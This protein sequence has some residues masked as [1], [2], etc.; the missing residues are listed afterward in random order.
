MQDAGQSNSNP[1]IIIRRHQELAVS[2]A[3]GI[4]NPVMTLRLTLLQSIAAQFYDNCT[5]VITQTIVQLI[6]T[7]QGSLINIQIMCTLKIERTV[8]IY[9][10]YTYKHCIYDIFLLLLLSK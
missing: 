3:T 9:S 2:M 5:I 7:L 1:N 10:S 6:R 8:H 4:Q